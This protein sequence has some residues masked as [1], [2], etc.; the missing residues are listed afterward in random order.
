MVERLDR[1]WFNAVSIV[2]AA[3]PF[4]FAG[5][6]V[7]FVVNRLRLRSAAALLAAALA[8]GCDCSINGF[9]SV[10][11]RSPAPLAGAAIVWGAACNPIALAT[12]VTV[13]GWRL[14]IAR[15]AGSAAAAITIWFAWRFMRVEWLARG[16]TSFEPSSGVHELC[17]VDEGVAAHLEGGLRALLPAAL[18]GASIPALF[19]GRLPANA[20]PVVAA[21][22]GAALSPCSSADPV[23]AS[24]FAREA[25]AQAAFMTASQCVDVR[26]LAIVYRHFGPHRTLLAAIAGA[27]GCA[28]AALVATALSTVAPVTR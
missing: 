6:F 26:L 10:L 2:L 19:A 28:S 23:L 16:R 22:L 24:V 11:A 20:P 25:A 14:A 17:P 12:T 1:I 8:P 7:A 5:A 4:V 18:L 15:A 9:V 13:F 27:L 3:A 21:L